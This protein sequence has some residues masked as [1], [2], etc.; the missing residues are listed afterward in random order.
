MI[1]LISQGEGEAI[2]FKS[3]MRWDYK[4]NGK[5]KGL[6]AVIAKTVA[7]FMNGQGG[8]LLIGVGPGGEVLGLQQDYGTLSKEPNRDGYE[9]KLTQVVANYL[10]KEY[11]PLV[12]VSFVD[13]D[14]KDV[15]WVRV[16]SSPKPVYLEENGDVRFYVRVGN[17]T[18]PMNIKQS[19]EYI[20]MHWE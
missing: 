13:V 14:G 5:N 11:G 7:G 2:E 17:T 19:S 1:E 15:C 8:T 12:H 10:G 16:D 9:Q 6:E 3:S 18:Q 4:A 20:S